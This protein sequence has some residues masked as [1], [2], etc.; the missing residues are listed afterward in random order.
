MT[1]PSK[2]KRLGAGLYSEAETGTI[3][4][5]VEEALADFGWDDTPENREIAERLCHTL[6]A[7]AFPDAEWVVLP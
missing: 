6:V 4:W 3:H 1:P 5:Y 7:A 2:L